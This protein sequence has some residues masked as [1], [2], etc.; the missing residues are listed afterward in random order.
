M[1]W[2]T[3]EK[4]S[5]VCPQKPCKTFNANHKSNYTADMLMSSVLGFV[6]VVT[7][8]HICATH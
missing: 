3:V 5:T 4:D 2:G 1:D 8:A 6:L 7:H